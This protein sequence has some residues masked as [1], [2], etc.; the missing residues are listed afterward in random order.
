MWRLPNKAVVLLAQVE[1]D[2]EAVE[3]VVNSE[4]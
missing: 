1:A 4:E 2:D 3:E